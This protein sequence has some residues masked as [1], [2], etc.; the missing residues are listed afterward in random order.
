MRSGYIF[1]LT[2]KLGY[3]LNPS[4]SELRDL[5]RDAGLR[6]ELANMTV[7]LTLPQFRQRALVNNGWRA[8]GGAAL[9]TYFT[10]ACL[11]VFVNEYRKQLRYENEWRAHSR[12]DVEVISDLR[13]GLDPESIAIGNIWVETEFASLDERTRAALKLFLAGYSQSEMVELLGAG[14]VRAVEGLLHRWRKS[15]EARLGGGRHD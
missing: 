3:F 13:S 4:D 10:G 5:A 11:R 15:A 9:A 7:A 6:N 12:K 8:E 2:N 14:S 1:Q